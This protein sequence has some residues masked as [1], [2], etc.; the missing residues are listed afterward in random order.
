MVVLL[1]LIKGTFYQYNPGC[2]DMRLAYP[3]MATMVMGLLFFLV[4]CSSTSD[5][6]IAYSVAE[7]VEA[8]GREQQPKAVSSESVPFRGT[9]KQL[10]IW[11]TSGWEQDAEFGERIWESEENDAGTDFGSLSFM[12]GVSAPGGYDPNLMIIE[13][14]DVPRKSNLSD[15]YESEIDNML[16]DDPTLV[17][18]DRRSLQVSGLSAE[19]AE[20]VTPNYALHQIYLIR[21]DKLWL[22][23]CAGSRPEGSRWSECIDALSGVR[24]D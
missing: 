2:K 9:N 19:L 11:L 10:T 13:G 23:Q 1:Q 20:M 6:K 4:G 15:I 3:V 14:H 5:D 18:T 8:V 7:T 17:I 22:M 24:F 12:A 21:K 16:A